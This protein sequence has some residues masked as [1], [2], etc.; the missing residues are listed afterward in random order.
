[1]R[2]HIF[3]PTGDTIVAVNDNTIAEAER[4]IQRHWDAGHSLFTKEG[5]RIGTG[6]PKERAADLAAFREM[7]KRAEDAYVVHPLA[8]G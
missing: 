5:E 2:L 8:G 1:M 7:A 4:I 3:D 6:N